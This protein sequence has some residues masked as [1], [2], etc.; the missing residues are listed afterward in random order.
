MNFSTGL[1]I[2]LIT[3]GIIL[4]LLVNLTELVPLK[5]V[6]T[7]NLVG[8]ILLVGGVIGLLYILTIPEDDYKPYDKYPTYK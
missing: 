5:L 7:S 1:T 4:I 8:L 2:F 6:L 3:V